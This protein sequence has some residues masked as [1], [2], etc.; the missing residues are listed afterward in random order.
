V[1]A[2]PGAP[3]PPATAP[4]PGQAAAPEAWSDAVPPGGYVCAVPKPS[5]PDGICGMPVESEPCNL[6]G[7][8]YTRDDV[9]GGQLAALRAENERLL[10][11]VAEARA[12]LAAVTAERDKA[13]RERAHLVAYLAACHP[14][15]ITDAPDTDDA[16]KIIYVETPAG[17]MSWHLSGDDLDLFLHVADTGD[18]PGGAPEWDGHSTEQKYERLAELTRM[19][20]EGAQ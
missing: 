18:V 9:W 16:W 13:Y 3:V 14:S 7:P 12:Q 8:T 15:V 20:V 1:T 17:Q 5:H 2:V 6:H 11:D 4:E 19:T 10:A